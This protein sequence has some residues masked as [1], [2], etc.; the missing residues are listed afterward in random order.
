[1]PGA[2]AVFVVQQHD[3]IRVGVEMVEGGFRQLLDR[4]FGRQAFEVELALLGA[5]F[6]VDP[7]QHGEIERVLVAEV[8][9]DRAA[10]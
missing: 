4:R 1:M 3:E 10:C 2:A 9:I 7:F 6:L 8:V 5:D